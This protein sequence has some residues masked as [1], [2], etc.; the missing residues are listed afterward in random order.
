MKVIT[1]LRILPN[2]NLGWNFEEIR[3]LKC[4]SK[5]SVSVVSDL[6]KSPH[7]AQ[8]VNIS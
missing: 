2:M 7:Y 5:F 4:V 3:F 6:H 1:I 8:S